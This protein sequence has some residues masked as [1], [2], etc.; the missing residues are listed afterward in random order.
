M[1]VPS[2]MIF[3]VFVVMNPRHFDVI[4]IGS[5]SGLEISSMAAKN[6]LKVAVVEKGAFGGTCLNRGCIPSKILLHSADTVEQVKN[7]HKFG[8][9]AKVER[10]DWSF[11]QKRV[12][13]IIDNDAKNIE[14]GNKETKNITVFKEEVKFVG[15]KLISTSNEIITAEKIFVCAGARPQI[16]KINGL[17]RVKYY[18]YENIMRIKKIPKSMIIIGGGYIASEMAHLFH[19]MGSKI[20][21]VNRS[22]KLLKREDHEISEKFTEISSKKY[23]LVLNAE[24]SRVVE[25]NKK[26]FLTV[27]QE[28]KEKEIESEALLVAAGINPNTDILDVE[29][30]G[31]EVDEKGFLKV[32]DFME[33]GVQGIWAIGDIVGKFL[34]KHNANL[35]VAYCAHNAFNPKNKAKVDYTAMPHAI[36]SSPQI[37]GVGMTE[38]ELQEKKIEYGI[39]KYEYY[40]TAMGQAIEE[41]KGF[42]KVLAGKKGNILGCHIMGHEAATL[43]HEVIVAMK[44]RLGVHGITSAVHIHPA[45]NEVVQRAFNRIRF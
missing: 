5:G 7:A 27:K 35:E 10:I 17:D 13:G 45:L 31:L 24:I 8:I 6:G 22:E 20:T 36:F 9:K 34:F 3:A 43:I 33:T 4:V 32:D 21:I 39:G 25:K 41:K 30:T 26:I 37:A 23:E 14:E 38:Q 42:V 12:W 40:H 2:L 18:T 16:P 15:K 11:I 28:N 19:S 29:K 44:S 1:T